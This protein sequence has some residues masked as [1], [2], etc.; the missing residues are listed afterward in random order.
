METVLAESDYKILRSH[1]PFRIIADQQKKEERK[2]EH[3]TH[4][5]CTGK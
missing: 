5:V 4:G 1:F 3:F 2:N